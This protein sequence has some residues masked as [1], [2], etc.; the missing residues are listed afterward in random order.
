MDR[1]ALDADAARLFHIVRAGPSAK[2]IATSQKAK[3]V[4]G[5][6]QAVLPKCAP[7]K[8][9]ADPPAKGRDGTAV[10]QEGATLVHDLQAAGQ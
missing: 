3:E 10:V 8:M 7:L 5:S 9:E 4:V 6:P 2:T 1:W